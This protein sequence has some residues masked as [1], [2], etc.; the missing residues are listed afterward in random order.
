MRALNVDVGLRRRS[1]NR[2]IARDQR[3]STFKLVSPPQ[4]PP[5]HRSGARQRGWL[6]HAAVAPTAASVRSSL[7][8]AAP[9]RVGSYAAAGALDARWRDA[10][11]NCCSTCVALSATAQ[12]A[13]CAPGGSARECASCSRRGDSSVG[14]AGHARLR[15]RRDAHTLGRVSVLLAAA[16]RGAP[17]MR[18]GAPRLIAGGQPRAARL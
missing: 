3:G 18:I 14:H 7:P 11:M 10:A 8:A 13:Y 12:M 15:K 1:F 6:D 2:D 16:A 17:L 9:L 5:R 4:L